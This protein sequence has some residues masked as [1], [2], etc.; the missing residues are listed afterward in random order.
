MNGFLNLNKPPGLTSHDVVARVRRLVGRQVKVGHAGTLDPAAIG[1]LPVALGKATRLIEYLADVRKGYRALVRLGVTTSTDDAEGEV[2]Q[3]QPA[4]LL[5]TSTLEAALAPLRG[6]ILQVPPMYS[7]LHCQGKRLYELAREG[8]TIDR[9]PRPVT[10]YT[11]EIREPGE[12]SEEFIRY[13]L[14]IQTAD[15]LSLLALE[16]ECSKGAYIRALAR[17]LGI[18]LGCGAHL[19]AL[20]RTFVGSF[21]LEQSISL[22]MLEKDAAQLEQLLLP[23]ETAVANWPVVTLDAE[24]SERVRHG[25]AL[26]SCGVAGD[27]VRA[28]GPDGALLAILRRSGAEWRPEKVLA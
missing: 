11:L 24:Q 10:V 22:A 1:V 3:E 20:E 17:D 18:N 28:H 2:L 16:V 9:E 14:Q 27:Y 15:V 13:G 26:S 5:D 4:P 23:L 19:A 25:M 12:I 7:A 21:T 8:R 6:R